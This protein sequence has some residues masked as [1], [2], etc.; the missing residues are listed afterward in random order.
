M[1]IQ[2]FQILQ[3]LNH[4]FKETL[5]TNNRIE[6]TPVVF[7][8]NKGRECYIGIKKETKVKRHSA[9]LRMEYLNSSTF[10][11]NSNGQDQKNIINEIVKLLFKE[12]EVADTQQSFCT[13]P[14]SNTQNEIEKEDLKF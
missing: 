10:S 11:D 2:D 13:Y 3:N 4:E 9:S 12:L 1:N 5:S 8:N 7:C 6:K 14:A